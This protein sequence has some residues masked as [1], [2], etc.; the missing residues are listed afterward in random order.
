[1]SQRTYQP[2]GTTEILSP[3][4]R[5]NLLRPDGAAGTDYAVQNYPLEHQFATEEDYVNGVLERDAALETDWVRWLTFLLGEEEYA[6][7]LETVLELIKPR[8]F[9]ELPGV[10]DFVCGILSLRGE[11]VPVI[12]LKMR[13]RLAAGPEQT[14][15]RII[16]CDGPEQPIGLLVD[17]IVQVVRLPSAAI[18]PPPLALNE[19]K[20]NNVSA[21]GRYQGRLLILLDPDVILQI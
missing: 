5:E 15:Q 17:R 9:T 7:S 3:K 13:L 2:E 19:D 20:N 1:V 16:V 6:L 11:V 12:D 4:G 14:Q 18:E 8:P 21:V 10:P